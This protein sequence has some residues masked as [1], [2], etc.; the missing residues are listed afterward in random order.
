[1]RATQ[2]LSERRRCN[3]DQVLC[4]L[5]V[6]ASVLVM[7]IVFGSNVAM[8]ILIGFHISIFDIQ[9]SLIFRWFK[10]NV[11]LIYS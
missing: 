5:C 6:S 1:M 8:D 3:L 10:S 11:Q 2:C 9:V 7:F 4:F